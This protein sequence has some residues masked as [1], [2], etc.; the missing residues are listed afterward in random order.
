MNNL[1]KLDNETKS[2]QIWRLGQAKANGLLDIT[3]DEIA[4]IINEDWCPDDCRTTKTYYNLYKN[5]QIFYDDGMFATIT[6]DND[7]IRDL[8]EQKQEI[9]KEKQKLFD[10]RRDLNAKLRETARYEEDIERICRIFE[11]IGKDRYVEYHRPV[12]KFDSNKTII[13]CLSDLHIGSEWANH[14]GYFSSSV[15]KDRLN[16]YIGK[17]VEIAET[18]EVDNAVVS[19]LGDGISGSIHK[20]IQVTNKENVVEQ[21]KLACEYVSDFVYELSK[22]FASVEFHSVSGNHTRLD[23]KEDALTDERLDTLIPW[24]LSNMLK[25]I[26]NIHIQ[27]EELD[28]TMFSFNIGNEWYVGV[29]GD[30]D[31]MNDT[32]IAKL[33]MW[34]GYKPSCVLMGHKHH[35][36]M[37]EVSGVKVI[38]SGSLCGSGDNFTRE[39]RLRCNASQ[40]VLV[41]DS[42]G[43][44]ESIYPVELH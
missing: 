33:C 4:D 20:S 27:T 32:S 31:S 12:K 35:P 1:H 2:K 30:Y 37:T 15:A 5:A 7:L 29:H 13:V 28:S 24:F 3:W 21:I 19:L 18:N 8:T 38:Q 14:T 44:I 6:N 34:L 43:K 11:T 9:K 17:I 23:K 42:H 10:E 41:C 22:H 16:K 36:A 25:G 39:K 26:D 40:T